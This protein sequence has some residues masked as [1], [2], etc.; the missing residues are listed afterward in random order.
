MLLMSLHFINVVRISGSPKT[1]LL[2]TIGCLLF[3]VQLKIIWTIRLEIKRLFFPTSQKPKEYSLTARGN[4]FCKHFSIIHSSHRLIITALP[5][6]EDTLLRVLL[7]QTLKGNQMC[8]V[9]QP[10]YNDY[11]RHDHSQLQLL[12]V[13]LYVNVGAVLRSWKMPK[14]QLCLSLSLSEGFLQVSFHQTYNYIHHIIT[15]T[16][17]WTRLSTVMSSSWLSLPTG[18]LCPT[19]IQTQGSKTSGL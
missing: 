17:C 9:M 5:L 11:G 12:A 1:E 16:P 6:L 15:S 19:V 2:L 7:L 18:F 14:Q 10:A 4:F 8:S 3:R 13:T